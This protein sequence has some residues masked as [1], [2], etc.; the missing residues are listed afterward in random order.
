MLQ[1]GAVSRH[2][3][4]LANVPLRLGYDENAAAAPAAGGAEDGDAETAQQ[5][6]R[7][8]SN[9]PF[10]SGSGPLSRP[11]PAGGRRRVAGCAAHRLSRDDGRAR[12]RPADVAEER[13]RASN[14]DARRE[15][16]VMSPRHD[17]GDDTERLLVFS[18]L[19]HRRLRV[20]THYANQ[21]G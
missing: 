3:R 4:R 17:P 21:N 10:R 19:G 20:S 2:H 12:G 1:P 8:L 5:Q 6:V 16:T 13:R 7:T 9:Q 11:P 14:D 15:Y 18:G